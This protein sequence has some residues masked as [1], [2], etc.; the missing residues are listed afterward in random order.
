M[1]EEIK[2]RQSEEV[3]SGHAAVTGGAS[4]N[5]GTERKAMISWAALLDEAVKRLDQAYRPELDEREAG[6]HSRGLQPLPQLFAEGFR[7]LVCQYVSGAFITVTLGL[8]KQAC[9]FRPAGLPF[10]VNCV[11]PLRGESELTP[12]DGWLLV[13]SRSNP[14]GALP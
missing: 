14:C 3:T 11:I 8:D 12:G 4:R 6:L 9:D 10:P 5:G 13:T 7:R 1:T 2:S